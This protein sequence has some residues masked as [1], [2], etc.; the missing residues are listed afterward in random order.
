MDL[1]SMYVAAASYFSREHE[2]ALFFFPF[3][4]CFTF[5]GE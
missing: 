3:I 5:D 1:L 4:R 2:F